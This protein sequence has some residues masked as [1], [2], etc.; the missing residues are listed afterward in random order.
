MGVESYKDNVGSSLGVGRSR[1]GSRPH[2]R[3]PQWL[4]YWEVVG[5]TM[6][7]APGGYNGVDSRQLLHLVCVAKTVEVLGCKSCKCPWQW[8]G[9]MGSLILVKKVDGVFLLF[10]LSLKGGCGQ[11]NP[12]W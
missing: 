8:Q 11:G 12:S 7:C 4:C 9:L 2:V 1:D 5:D 10:F 6:V 3:L